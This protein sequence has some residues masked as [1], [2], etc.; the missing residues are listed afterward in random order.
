MTG[1][2][3]KT[4][5][6]PKAFQVVSG[7]PVIEKACAVKKSGVFQLLAESLYSTV[8]RAPV[9]PPPKAM[10]GFVLPPPKAAL[11]GEERRALVRPAGLH[12]LF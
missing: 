12:C 9:P 7:C 11:Y 10:P 1:G 8:S 4:L 2:P 5:P 3:L 6:S